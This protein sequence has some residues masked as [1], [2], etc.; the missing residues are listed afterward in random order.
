MQELLHGNELDQKLKEV[1]DADMAQPFS[2]GLTERLKAVVSNA[3]D[4]DLGTQL[5]LAL[6]YIDDRT[7]EATLSDSSKFA[8]HGR[9]LAV[10]DQ[11]ALLGSQSDVDTFANTESVKT[12]LR[13]QDLKFIGAVA[14]RFCNQLPRQLC[15]ELETEKGVREKLLS[16]ANLCV[17]SVIPG[18][19]PD[20]LTR[21]YEGTQ[22]E[23]E[24]IEQRIRDRDHP[25]EAEA[26]QK[27]A[28]AR[29][30][31]WQAALDRLQKFPNEYNAAVADLRNNDS[32]EG[33][34]SQAKRLVQ[35]GLA[36]MAAKK[37]G[38]DVS[39]EVE[40]AVI[41]DLTEQLKHSLTTS[42]DDHDKGSAVKLEDFREVL[43]HIIPDRESFAKW[44]DS[45]SNSKTKCL[46]PAML[47]STCL[48]QTLLKMSAAS[49]K[50]TAEQVPSLLCSRNAMQY[51]SQTNTSRVKLLRA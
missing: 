11:L 18:K 29:Q 39:D 10:F 14:M 19:I 43:V 8:F 50:L 31:A 33:I 25:E 36:V 4:I 46:K 35:Y 28:E 27:E 2:A 17:A 12:F 34:G 26:R 45:Y 3:S 32:V 42:V 51:S 20:E 5:P 30:K 22:A 1:L 15:G 16:I 23:I 41:E 49:S 47:H 13:H 6:T 48:K 24:R 21:L 9:I 40:K 38:V 44:A 7:D 37:R